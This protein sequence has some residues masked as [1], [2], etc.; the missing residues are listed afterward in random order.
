MKHSN[1][2]N[3]H[4][5]PRNLN[6]DN[7]RNYFFSDLDKVDPKLK[8]TF[9]NQVTISLLLIMISVTALS[10]F[11]FMLS[12][13]SDISTFLLVRTLGIIVIGFAIILFLHK[14]LK[15]ENA[16]YK[17]LLITVCFIA[18]WGVAKDIFN[19][20][21][22]FNSYGML[23][24]SILFFALIFMPFPPKTSLMLGAYCSGLYLVLWLL[25]VMPDSFPPFIGLL[26]DKSHAET[27]VANIQ[28]GKKQL[29]HYM[30]YSAWHIVQY[31]IYGG[32]A[33]IF[34][35]AN[36]QSFIKAF[37][38]DKELHSKEAELKAARALLLKPENQHLEFKSSAR[39]DFRQNRTNKELEKII[40]KTIAGFMNSD[41]G[42]LFLGVDDDGNPVGLRHDYNSLAKKDSDGYQLF[43]VGLI[44]IYF[45]KGLFDNIEITF[46]NMGEHEVCI[47]DVEPV[48]EPV[49]VERMDGAFFVRTGNNTQR[50]NTKEALEYIEKHFS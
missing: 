48:A 37:L 16:D 31:L 25:L 2:K 9:N 12:L 38:I 22:V 40:V 42:M 29:P 11:I 28:Y 44:S 14:I 30:F 33:F 23:Y 39:W 3:R 8:A 19:F 1:N 21:I 34:R 7:F 4:I 50:L 10:A 43:L 26:I 47:V 17:L 20:G 27:L 46:Q 5:I 15:G 41:G 36:M 18:S 13:F 24:I 35:A 6:I 45:G 32:L 49:F